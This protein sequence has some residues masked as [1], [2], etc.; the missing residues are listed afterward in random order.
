MYVYIHT[1]YQLQGQNHFTAVIKCTTTMFDNATI[2]AQLK[3][4]QKCFGQVDIANSANRL[5]PSTQ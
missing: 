4:N 2:C 1:A 5:T 3:Y